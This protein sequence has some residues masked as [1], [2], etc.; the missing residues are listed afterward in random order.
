MFAVR[1]DLMPG[2]TWMPNKQSFVKRAACVPTMASYGSANVVGLCAVGYA[3]LIDFAT[4]FSQERE[5]ATTGCDC[6]HA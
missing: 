1:R 5:L 2:A 4:A 3:H 6:R